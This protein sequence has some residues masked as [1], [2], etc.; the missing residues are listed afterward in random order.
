[1]P[2]TA[3]ANA[4]FSSKGGSESIKLGVPHFIGA[5]IVLV[6]AYLF[7]RNSGTDT[8]A[9]QDTEVKVI[10]MH[11]YSGMEQGG[12]GDHFLLP[13]HH[14]GSTV[15]LPVRFPARSGHE[16]SCLI[17]QGFSGIYASNPRD[18]AWMDAPPSEVQ[19]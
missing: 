15:T 4:G 2:V 5:A 6:L 12:M 14:V 19:L 17:D 13:E 11:D 8:P 1:M 18:A 3:S 16:I 7:L 10:G 9:R